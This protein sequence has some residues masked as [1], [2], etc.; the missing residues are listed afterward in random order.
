MITRNNYEEFFML[1]TDNE[2]SDME[3]K[4]VEEFVAANPDL[5]E[6]LYALQQSVLKPES[7]IVFENKE[8]LMKGTT[9][10]I[11]QNN[12]E[13]Y[14]LLYTDNELSETQKKEVELFATSSPAYAQ[15][16]HLFSQTHVE[17]DVSVVFENK[18]VLY[19]KEKDERVI[20][21]FWIKIAAAVV[22]LMLVAFFVFNNKRNV[23]HELADKGTRKTDQHTNDTETVAK[24]EIKN[25]ANV[26]SST[27]LS[28]ENGQVEPNQTVHV[29]VGQ[30]TQVGKTVEPSLSTDAPINHV[31]SNIIDKP[32]DMQTEKEEINYAKQAVQKENIGTGNEDVVYFGGLSAKKNSL[33]GL[34]RKVSRVLNKNADADNE[35]KRGILIGGFQTALK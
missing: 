25:A 9:P 17:A 19:K 21:L 13:E 26:T 31:A 33:R 3:R 16:L 29:E 7:N 10:L 15:E 12:F 22:I 11:N 30:I 14:V 20:P 35:D 5:K 27:T 24:K 23:Q 18:D 8:I 4:A 6:E 28:G 32:A 1:Y 2:L 34:F